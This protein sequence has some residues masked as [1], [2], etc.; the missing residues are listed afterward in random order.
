[1]LAEKHNIPKPITIQNPYS[2][3]NR[4]YEVGL[5]E[6]S[7]REKI[8]LLAYSPLGGGHLTGKY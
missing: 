6:I 1:K 4:S 8:G 7:I 2:L 5:S 3:L